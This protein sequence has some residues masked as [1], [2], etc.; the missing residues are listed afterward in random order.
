MIDSHAHL[1]MEQFDPDREEVIQRARE[2]GLSH[3]VTIGIDL[4]TSARSLELAETH[5][6]ISATIGCHPHN[7]KEFGELEVEGLAA[8]AAREKVV[9]WGEIGLDFF[10]KHSPPG[11][12]VE[13]FEMQLDMARDFDLPVVIHDR[14]AHDEVMEILK[15]KQAGLYKGVFHCFSGDYDMAMTLIDMGFYISIPGTVTFP[16]AHQIQRVAARIPLERML[17]ETDAPFLAPVPHRGKRNEPSFVAHTVSQIA[18][19]RETGVEVVAERTAE[20][21]RRVFHLRER[22]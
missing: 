17:V 16:K 7:A 14:D 12:Q 4:D 3:I 2:L 20:N 9:A 21:A 1:D 13:A 6:F 15:K 11:R 8:L 18:R 22:G 10:H 5:D 19:L